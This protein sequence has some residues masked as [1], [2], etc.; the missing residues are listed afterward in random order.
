MSDYQIEL[1]L[2]N[3][4]VSLQG[5]IDEGC[6][7]HHLF[8]TQNGVCA[9]LVRYMERYPEHILSEE[10]S[11]IVDMYLFKNMLNKQNTPFK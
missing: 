2:K 11:N 4:F 5:W 8:D 7:A 6:P 3:F 10:D 1:Y 9:N